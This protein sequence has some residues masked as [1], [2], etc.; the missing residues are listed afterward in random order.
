MRAI[1]LERMFSPRSVAVIGANIKPGRVGGVVTRNLLAGGFE[2]PIMPVN[3]RYD[4]VAGVLTYP[5]V[6]SLPRVPDLA[7]LCTPPDT[8][9]DLVDELGSRGA[10][11]ALVMARGLGTMRGPDGRTLEERTLLAARAHGIRILGGGSL[12]LL[13]PHVGLN[14]SFSRVAALPGHIGFVSQ[15]DAVGTLL[16]DWAH[17]RRVGFS[18]FVSL[19]DASDVGFGE[20]LDYLG[21]DPQTR[22]ILLYVESLRDRRSF[23][24]AAR[25]AA[26]N[27]PVLAIKAGRASAPPSVL[28][29]DTLSLVEPDDVFD[30]ALRR[31]GVVRVRDV[32]EL[33]DAA[34]T[35]AHARPLSGERLA[36]VS[37]G[38]GVGLIVAD[39][40][41]A[42]GLRVAGLSPAL[43]SRLRRVMPPGWNGQNPLDILVDAPSTRYAALLELLL[44]SREF[45][46]VLAIHT[47]S[48]LADAA[49]IAAALVATVKAHP[50]NVLAAFGGGDSPARRLLMD[51]GIPHFDGPLE[52][53]RAFRT[54]VSHRRGFEALLQTPPSVPVEFRVDR[55]VARRVIRGA[56]DDGRD[57]LRVVETADVLG[58]YGIPFGELKV[59]ETPEEAGRVARVLGFPVDVAIR[60]PQVR[61]KREVGGIARALESAEAVEDAARGMV[62]RVAEWRPDARVT[63]FSVQRVPPRRFARE[64]FVGAAVDPLFGPVILFGEGRDTELVRDF[65][66]ALPPLNLPLA[67][68]LVAR[69]RVAALLEAGPNRPAADLDA[70]CLTLMKV[71]Q[72]M[73]DH[74]EIVEI[75]VNPLLA[76]E[77]GVLAVGGFM[78]VAPST[79]RG[80]ERLAIRPYPEG[81]EER[82][83]LKDGSEVTLRPVRPGDEAAHSDFVSRLSPEDSH[84]RF[85][86]TVRTMPRT[87][88]ARLTQIDYD[89][90]MAFVATRPAPG[91]GAETI[92]VVR[93]VADGE[94][95]TAELSI[96]VRSDLKRRGLGSHLLR[97]AIDWCHSRGTRELAGDVLAEN[98]SMLELTRHFKGFAISDSD[99]QGIVRISHPL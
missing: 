78:A 84:F 61:R 41:A 13:S 62:A 57:F 38:G 72:L 93:T 37:N 48:T 25:G 4:A 1:D 47:P 19:G 79:H 77:R 97:K 31:A 95:E 88:L 54:M 73:A 82:V 76:D 59:V 68:E 87:E 53:A 45:D 40:L 28:S 15:S 32:A 86:H 6:A 17:P 85:F 69:T 80:A 23:M 8:V 66:V 75:D 91:G 89:R 71:S 96:V 2:G 83:T 36:V 63:G 52:A 92:G 14:A 21:S 67:R 46:A 51:G 43:A 12:G 90:E 11:A 18:H 49:E 20:V 56:L 34:E 60:S 29:A 30:A 81:L 58:A 22:A 24:A 39:E 99:E 42:G 9:P 10:R 3:P 16:L 70:I 7:I 35:L 55:E 94:N 74:P 50:G 27:K 65:A 33:F 98:E 44:D 5:D 26:R 64:L